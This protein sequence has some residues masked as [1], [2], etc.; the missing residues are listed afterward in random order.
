MKTKFSKKTK[1]AICIYLA[2]LLLLYVVVEILPKV[3]DIFETTQVLEPGTLKLSYETKGYFIKNE[4]V[5]IASESGDIQYLVGIGTA[6][7]KGHPIVSV[8][9]DGDDGG[10]ARFSKYTERLKGYE[11]LSEE[12][13]APVSGVFGLTTDGYE[14]YFTPEKMHKIKRETVEGL[15]YDSAE[16]ERSS[17]IKGEPIYKISADD[18]WYVLCWVDSETAKSYS[19]GRNVI[20]ELPEGDVEAS[21][22]SI[23]KDGSDYRVIFYLDVYYKAFCESRA[24]DMAIVISDN[25]GL[26]VDNKCIIEKDGKQGVY[27][28][29]KNGEYVFNRISIISSDEKQSVIEDVTFIDDEGNQVYTVDVYDEVLKHPKNALQKDLKKEAEASEDGES[30]E[31]D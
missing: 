28:K 24:E 10:N 7:K 5:G 1:K 13:D 16:L 12:Y 17:V 23:K 14:D 9:S 11:G 31:E 15:S 25:E 6:V 30:K 18:N 27:V 3:T 26:I 21:V 29:N 22:Y 8:T 20:L 2:A 19:E 4:T